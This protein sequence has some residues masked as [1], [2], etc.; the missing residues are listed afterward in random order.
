MGV[1]APFLLL[2]A[3]LPRV[4]DP[5]PDRIGLGFLATAAGTGALLATLAFAAADARRRER[6][7]LWG[8]VVGFAVGSAIYLVSLAAQLFSEI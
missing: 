4:E 7:T 8:T 2:F 6:A 5:W 3:I 1:L